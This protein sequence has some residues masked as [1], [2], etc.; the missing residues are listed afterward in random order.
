[1]DPRLLFETEEE[2][3]DDEDDDPVA[4]APPVVAGARFTR[5]VAERKA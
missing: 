3:D 1:V 5:D 4:P 2:L